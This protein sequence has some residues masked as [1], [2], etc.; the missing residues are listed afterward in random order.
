MQPASDIIQSDDISLAIAT[1]AID[2]VEQLLETG[3]IQPDSC[4]RRGHTPLCLA[5][6]YGRYD[7]A[8]LFIE[9]GADVRYTIPGSAMTPLHIASSNG[10]SSIVQL[11][12]EM[13]ADKIAR[14]QTGSTPMEYAEVSPQPLD[15]AE[16]SRERRD[17][18]DDKLIRMRQECVH[19]LA[20]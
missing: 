7:I 13:G 6:A 9:R 11:L 17:M 10:F 15:L 20:K 2:I 16:I 14:D 3:A 12:V 8:K 1:D 18:G 4:D 5:A 19:L